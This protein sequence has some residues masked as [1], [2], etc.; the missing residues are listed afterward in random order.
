MV[1]QHARAQLFQQ[2]EDTEQMSSAAGGGGAGF[3]SRD[4]LLL[5]YLLFYLLFQGAFPRDKIVCKIELDIAKI[6]S[7]W[8]RVG[9]KCKYV[10][11]R[12]RERKKE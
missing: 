3:R 12:E 7:G 10:K 5:R 11:R 8:K 9:N 2:M 6:S 4:S 1:V